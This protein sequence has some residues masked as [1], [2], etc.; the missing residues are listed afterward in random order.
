MTPIKRSEVI[1]CYTVG[2][3]VFAVIQAILIV[4][5]SIFVLQ[6]SSAGNIGWILLAMVLLAV[7]A[8]LF[9][10]TISIFASSELQVVQMIPFYHHS[11]SVFFRV[12]SLRL[13]SLSSRNFELYYAY[14]LRSSSNQR[15]HGLW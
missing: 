4:L 3:G 15:C 14:L 6:L 1:L 11:T 13:D 7:T 12:D 8:V 5:Y 10:A 9:G 2:Y